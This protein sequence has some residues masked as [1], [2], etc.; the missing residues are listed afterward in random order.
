[1]LWN[2]YV[3][4]PFCCWV[5]V[6]HDASSSRPTRIACLRLIVKSKFW[7]SS[8]SRV[9]REPDCPAPPEVKASL[10]RRVGNTDSGS[11]PDSLDVSSNLSSL[12][13]FLP[14]TAVLRTR[15]VSFTC[16]VS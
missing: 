14:I 7:A 12:N 10:T 1:M 2:T 6:T 5:L 15:N 13:T 8:S 11:V 4:F 3:P 9:E 16:S